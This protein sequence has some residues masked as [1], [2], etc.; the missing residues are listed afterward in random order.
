MLIMMSAMDL[1]LSV[2]PGAGAARFPTHPSVTVLVA[3]II[4]FADLAATPRQSEVA[5]ALETIFAAFDRIAAA[6]RLRPTWMLGDPYVATAG[7]DHAS[8]DHANRAAAT[9]LELISCLAAFGRRTGLRLHARVG[10]CSGPVAAGK[11]GSRPFIYDLW[12]GTLQAA[13]R[14][15][16]EGVADRVLVSESTRSLL[17]PRFAL[18]RHIPPPNG[19]A[20]VTPAWFV[21]RYNAS[22]STD[23]CIVA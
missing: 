19:P 11:F 8:G 7:L 6:N 13:T 17:G 4:G 3:D 23:R 9:G 5:N 10:L 14:L 20:G 21:T 16:R 1:M 12:G 2:L 22:S 18:E 15:E